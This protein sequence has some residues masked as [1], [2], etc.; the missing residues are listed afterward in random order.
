ML[1]I[2]LL[3]L[4]G[5]SFI[6]QGQEIGMINAPKDWDL[7]EYKDC[8]AVQYIADIKEASK[9]RPEIWQKGLE[10]LHLCGRDHA[11]TPF[12]WSGEAQAG[13]STNPKTWMSVMASYK[14]INA[15]KQENDPASVLSMYRHLLRLR[16]QYKDIFVYGNFTLLEPDHEHTFSYIKTAEDGSSAYIV[17]NFS[18]QPQPFSKPEAFKSSKLVATA[19]EGGDENTLQPWSGRVYLAQA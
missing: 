18:D 7:S 5:T 11:R 3:T 2:Y 17:L 13:F 9:E 16:Q 12:Q 8:H 19:V 4:S 15:A 10:G 14:E 1:A 6:Y